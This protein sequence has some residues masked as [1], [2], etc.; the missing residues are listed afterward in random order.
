[1][2][3][4]DSVNE[5]NVGKFYICNCTGWEDDH[6][7]RFAR[8]IVPKKRG[9]AADIYVCTG[10]GSCVSPLLVQPGECIEVSAFS[11]PVVTGLNNR[12]IFNGTNVYLQHKVLKVYEATLP[13]RSNG[14]LLHDIVPG[15]VP[16][17]G[18][19][20]YLGELTFRQEM[21]DR[22]IFDGMQPVTEGYTDDQSFGSPPSD[23][24]LF[25]KPI[26]WLILLIVLILIYKYY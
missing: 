6:C 26:T 17:C 15:Q 14:Y 2:S 12:L 22:G 13:R 16:Q 7:S 10:V 19:G 11:N 24:C 18:I 4:D 25:R 1:M 21:Q 5:C 8:D 23:R 9:T 20:G 3:D